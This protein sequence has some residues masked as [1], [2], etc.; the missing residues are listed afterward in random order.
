MTNSVDARQ[1]R[2]PFIDGLRGLFSLTVLFFHSLFTFFDRDYSD[3]GL[4]FDGV[5]AVLLFF[6]LS[7]FSLSV[8]YLARLQSGNESADLIIRRMAVARYPRLAL[9]SLA[10]C[11]LMYAVCS[12]GL[13]YYALIPA[14]AKPEW[15]GWAY[16][17]T[18]FTLS[19]V[20][21]FA[22][23]D[24]FFPG[25]FIPI[26]PYD[27]P[28][29]IT[30]LWTMSIE[31]VG[32]IL[33]FVYALA[34]KNSVWRVLL[35]V[36]VSIALTLSGSYYAFFFAGMLLA[37]LFLRLRACEPPVWVHFAA[38]SAAGILFL[39]GGPD[40]FYGKVVFC[41]LFVFLV[42]QSRYGQAFFSFAP[43]RYLGRI[44]F[45][46][47]LVHM[48]VII[49]LQSYLYLKY[50]GEFSQASVIAIAGGASILVSLM[51]AHA[52]AYIDS[53][54]IVISRKFAKAIVG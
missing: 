8:G 50:D 23:Y 1:E 17:D 44:S 10:A 46:L 18:Q 38:V 27:G 22:L 42:I 25:A 31:F 4:L 11:I 35:T 2:Y 5:V 20:I 7:G 32:S 48:P 49:S 41:T 21:K 14:E 52:F 37:D 43:F 3:F 51:L 28:Y 45:A 30:N 13:N 19:E 16:R 39:S 24:V 36:A 6:V 33:I 29:L 54:S 53:H 40:A 12:S 26:L 9:P 47:Y 15:W 34:M